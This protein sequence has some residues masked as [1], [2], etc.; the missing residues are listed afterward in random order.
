M[1]KIVLS[2]LLGLFLC[3]L[4]GCSIGLARTDDPAK[5]L[6][7]ARYLDPNNGPVKISTSK[8]DPNKVEFHFSKWDVD[9]AKPC[10]VECQKFYFDWLNMIVVPGAL[11]N[12]KIYSIWLDT[13]YP[14]SAL[15]NGLTILENDLAIHPLGQESRT[16]TYVGFCYLPSLKIGQVIITNPPCRYIQQQWEVRVLNLPVWQQKGVLIGLGLMKHFGY[17]LFDNVRKEVEFAPADFFFQTDESGSWENYSFEIK[18]EKIVVSMLIENKNFP[19]AFDTCGSYG[20]VVNFDTWEK[21]AKNIKNTKVKKSKFYSGFLGELPCYKARIKKLKIGNRV[22]KNAEVI[23]LPEDSPYFSTGITL[24]MKYFKN[25][26]VVLDFERNLMWVKNNGTDR[27]ALSF[28][29]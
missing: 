13:G 16:S 17:I 3:L 25:T 27:H 15:T 26:V 5:E 7:H 29:F 11:P 4:P 21:L 28:D 1:R 12:G 24:S 8:E 10:K 9:L 6:Q 19:V 14:G 2:I 22:V 20:M 23:I 18:N